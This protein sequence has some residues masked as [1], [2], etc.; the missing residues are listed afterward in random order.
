MPPRALSTCDMSP[1]KNDYRLATLMRLDPEK[2]A[3]VRR[4]MSG[5]TRC[6]N[7]DEP[8][9]ADQR[10]CVKCGAALYPDLEQT[11]KAQ[12]EAPK[13]AER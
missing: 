13:E 4:M 12:Q 9:R 7:C 2:L 11:E 5:T 8:N 10:R 6:P 1:D 3:A